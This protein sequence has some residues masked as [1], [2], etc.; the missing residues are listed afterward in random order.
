VP[1]SPL[2]G[3]FKRLRTDK[4]CPF[5]GDVS[6][7]GRIL[8]G[9]VISTKMTRTLII[10]RDYLHYIPKYSAKRVR[11][12]QG[13]RTN[14]VQTVTRSDTRTWRRMSHQH[15]VLRL[16]ILLLSVGDLWLFLDT[17][18]DLDIRV[19]TMPTTFKN[20]TIQCIASVEEQGS[21][22]GVWQVLRRTVDILCAY[23]RMINKYFFARANIGPVSTRTI[24]G[25]DRIHCYPNWPLLSSPSSRT[26]W[27]KADL[28][29]QRQGLRLHLWVSSSPR[30]TRRAQRTLSRRKTWMPFSITTLGRR[31]RPIHPTVMATQHR[32]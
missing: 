24:T 22:Q 29:P 19:R 28:I 15:S 23:D 5:T 3:R 7:R 26:V 25:V 2:Q 30:R 9:R 13:P 31:R 18:H 16:E 12:I 11:Y 10:R 14:F 8:T 6:I 17:H 4:K 21:S 32:A 20:C 27:V 1:R